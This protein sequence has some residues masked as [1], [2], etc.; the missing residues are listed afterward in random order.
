LWQLGYPAASRTEGERAVNEAREIGL[1]AS[2]MFALFWTSWNHMFYGQ[3][4]KAQSLLNE[5][6]DLAG[7][8]DASLFWK[9]TAM[10]FRGAL[11]V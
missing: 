11:F 6:A 2:L 8:K 3:Y 10:A 5:L 9:A 7:E 4:A 1:A